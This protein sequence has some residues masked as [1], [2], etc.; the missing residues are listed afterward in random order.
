M[1]FHHPVTFGATPP[2]PTRCGAAGCRQ[3]RRIRLS[4]DL[5]L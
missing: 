4:P 3:W 5:G 2:G 1:N